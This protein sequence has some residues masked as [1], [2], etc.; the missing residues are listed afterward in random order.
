[1][2]EVSDAMAKQIVAN[3]G[4]LPPTATLSVPVKKS[5]SGVDGDVRRCGIYTKTRSSWLNCALR[6]D[7]AVHWVS[8]GDYEAV[9]VSN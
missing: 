7:E 1:M 8:I 2:Q 5:N 6:D 9:A 4:E 3:N